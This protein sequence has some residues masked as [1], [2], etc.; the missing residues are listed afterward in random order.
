MSIEKPD[1]Q[2]QKKQGEQPEKEPQGEILKSEQSL[3][4]IFADFEGEEVVIELKEGITTTFVDVETIKKLRPETLNY[5]LPEGTSIR[6]VRPKKSFFSSMDRLIKIDLEYK[7]MIKDD[8][9]FGVKISNE[10]VSRMKT[11]LERIKKRNEGQL[12]WERED[13]DKKSKMVVNAGELD[14]LVSILTYEVTGSEMEDLGDAR[15]KLK[16]DLYRNKCT[17]LEKIIEIQG[18][19]GGKE[20]EYIELFHT[21]DSFAFRLQPSGTPLEDYE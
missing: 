20:K 2:F 18:E 19:L 14:Q 9:E 4:E 11:M 17:L 1:S 21:S 10:M 5:K 7:D 3:T 12:W 16:G 15:S 13:Q 8:G 6:T